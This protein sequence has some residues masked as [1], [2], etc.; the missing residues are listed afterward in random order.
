MKKRTVCICLVLLVAFGCLALSACV[1]TDAQKIVDKL[2]KAG[3]DTAIGEKIVSNDALRLMGVSEF[4]DD[5]AAL[6]S[7]DQ[8]TS[9]GPLAVF[10]G[11]Q[12]EV[13]AFGEDKPDYPVGVVAEG[14]ETTIG[15]LCETPFPLEATVIVGIK[16][17]KNEDGDEITLI[18]DY[19]VVILCV[20]TEDSDGNVVSAK[21]N[22]SK[23]Y[24]SID[25][26]LHPQEDEETPSNAAAVDEEEP[27]APVKIDVRRSG[28]IVYFGTVGGLR[29][30]NK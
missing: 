21:E 8:K 20:E 7:M 28:N 14:D 1:P 19:V 10:S 6:F 12:N 18:E 17:A 30:A 2:E 25:E 16:N 22:A 15:P 23:L 24:S 5:Y 27:V 11:D 3:F 26:Y 9:D 29:A 13:M 4:P